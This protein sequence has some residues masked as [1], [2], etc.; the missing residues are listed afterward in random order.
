M[1]AS[2]PVALSFCLGHSILRPLRPYPGSAP[3]ARVQPREVAVAPRK[4]RYLL[5][6]AMSGNLRPR[7]LASAG[8]TSGLLFSCLLSL[9]GSGVQ[10]RGSNLDSIL[11]LR[12]SSRLLK[13]T[14]TLTEKR[15][16]ALQVQSSIGVPLSVGQAV[17]REK[18]LGI[19]E[20]FAATLGGMQHRRNMHCLPTDL[21]SIL[22]SQPRCINIAGFQI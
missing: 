3:P 21:L 16:D 19:G 9:L 6:K 1:L 15:Q 5:A 20:S 18:G 4:Y 12:Q 2:W 10:N 8:R 13:L 11:Q 7:R 14:R 22:R 17:H